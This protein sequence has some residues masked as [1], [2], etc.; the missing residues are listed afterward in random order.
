MASFLSWMNFIT[1]RVDMKSTFILNAGFSYGGL[2]EKT[3]W[4]DT[5]ES[6]LDQ[7]FR[8]MEQEVMGQLDSLKASWVAPVYKEVNES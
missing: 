8:D 2:Q 1:L 4:I 3:V 6:N 7:A 5:H